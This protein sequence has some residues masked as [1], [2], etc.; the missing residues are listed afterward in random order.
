MMSGRVGFE[1]MNVKESSAIFGLH[2][3]GTIF[4]PWCSAVSFKS[5]AYSTAA[6]GEPTGEEL[7]E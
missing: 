2:I 4:N 1:R 3:S 7:A 6:V 5:T